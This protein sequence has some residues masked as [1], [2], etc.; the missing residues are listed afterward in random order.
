M[1][2]KCAS[3]GL[4]KQPRILSVQMNADL[5]RAHPGRSC[6]SSLMLTLPGVGVKITTSGEGLQHQLWPM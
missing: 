6:A 5:A 2:S 3:Q 1:S 4:N